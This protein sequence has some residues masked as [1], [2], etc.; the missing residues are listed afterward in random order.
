[1]KLSIRLASGET[2]TLLG[3]TAEAQ[4]YEELWR[5]NRRGA[6]AAVIKLREARLLR[7]Q[8]RLVSL[9]EHETSAFR[10]AI[11]K[12]PAALAE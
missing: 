12:V 1:M 2:V 11:E 8:A 10:E 9:D 7:S 3:G 5:I 4:L 6:V